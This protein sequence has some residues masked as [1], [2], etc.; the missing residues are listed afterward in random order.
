MELKVGQKIWI[1]FKEGGSSEEAEVLGKVKYHSYIEYLVMIGRNRF[2]LESGS[3]WRLWKKVKPPFKASELNKFLEKIK[4]MREI[5]GKRCE[6]LGELYVREIGFSQ[7][8]RVE[9]E[10]EGMKPGDKVMYIEGLLPEKIKGFSL[11]VIEIYENEIEYFL[12]RE[13]Q[14]Q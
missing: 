8:L 10:V 5:L 2:W 6:F 12:G 1:D 14:V 9:G 3:G 7:V 13:V 4:D 11:G